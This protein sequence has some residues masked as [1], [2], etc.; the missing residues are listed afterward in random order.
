MLKN[1]MRKIGILLLVSLT[2]FMFV[3]LT[4]A[5][6][7]TV[8]S[9]GCN[10]S[11][12][13]TAINLA[14]PGDTIDVSAGTY[15]E[16]LIISSSQTNLDISG[17]GSSTTTIK[18]IATVITASS[19]LAAPN[20]EILGLGTK[21]HGFT[22]ESP[23]YSSGFYSSGM[24][25]G[26]QNVEIYSNIFK[27]RGAAD[28]G[29]ISQAIQTY[30]KLAVPG[31]DISSL[32]IHNNV[33]THLSSSTAGYEAIWV[34]L[35]EG[36]GSIIIQ[37]NQ[38][39]GDV[40][41]AITTERGKATI[42]NNV[43]TTSLPPNVAGLGGWQGINIGGANDGS[44]STVF[45]LNNTI[46]GAGSGNGFNYGIKL[47]FAVTSS[48]TSVSLINNT[49][50]STGISGIWARYSANGITA[51]YNTLSDNVLGIKNDDVSSLNGENNYWG[52]CTGPGPVGSGSG[53]GVSTNVD[54]SPWLGTCITN[55][56]ISSS[57][58]FSYNDVTL[59]AN[60]SSPVCIGDVT[61]SVKIGSGSWKNYTGTKS[62]SGPANYSVT[63]KSSN[64]S[65][66]EQVN[67]TVF[68][69]DCF[70]HLVKD[71]NENF[72][73]NSKTT[74]TVNPISPNGLNS[75]Y[76]TEPLFTLANP[77]AVNKSYRWDSAIA[78][79]YAIPFNLTD[80]PNQPSQTAGILELNWWSSA[81]CGLEREQNQTFYVDLT[82]PTVDSKTPADGASTYDDTPLISAILDE[83]Y[84]EN[85]GVNKASISMKVD[86]VNRTSQII[87][88]DI[89]TAKVR[90]SYT[91]STP[92]NQSTHTVEITGQDNAG[93]QFS[94]TWQFTV[95]I[96]TSF[97]LNIT[98][99]VNKS[100]TTRQIPFTINLG[101][102]VK[103]L[104]YKDNLN[105]FRTL[106][107]NCNSYN[108][109]ITLGDG[110]H[111]IVIRATDS[112]G[113]SQQQTIE[114][115]IDSTPPRIVSIKPESRK[116]TNGSYVEVKYT[117]TNLNSVTV[118]FGNSSTIIN[119]AL[120][121]C[122]SGTNK[123]CNSSISNEIAQFNGQYIDVYFN[124][125]DGLST[126]L[127]RKSTVF[128][129]TSSPVL[130]VTAPVNNAN[131]KSFIQFNLTVN[132]SSKVEFRDHSTFSPRWTNL[133]TNCNKLSIKKSF[134]KGAH[135]VEVRATDKAGNS[136]TETRTFNMI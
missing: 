49:I 62:S 105:S 100:Y 52:S 70:G 26:A 28:G 86:G 29:E 119:K 12:I 71:G 6:T 103:T 131:Y 111:T 77:N 109:P 16:D 117:E 38:F 25:I 122:P 110:N 14:S 134:S 34:N 39:S 35:D 132:E 88:T 22:I 1:K 124:L 23:S 115:F 125:T 32:N 107:S 37:N 127:S 58:I 99:P 54:Y 65:G 113:N 79:P 89:T 20:I 98:S 8:C 67:W 45:V 11:S 53:S 19:P 135:N 87:K 66:N 126:A 9:S 129:D 69:D 46:N 108:K 84:G 60:V 59:Y 74:L 36:P 18:G 51:N 4:S 30:H 63:I 101:N 15:T 76:V 2:I 27:T 118:L 72:F 68:A 120:T 123:V 130:T 48:F 42:K 56:T 102:I 91:P 136:V 133:C 114:L 92:L 80:I 57:C 73:V 81:S 93:N 128:V 121:N 96:S 61:F 106:C 104:D 24:V 82:T 97:T 5:A 83:H 21:I 3:S 40:F 116:I 85:S 75:W 43:I 50:S 55:K 94:S 33:F 44:I 64:F 10:A 17:A 7:V 31:V 90:V 13:Q 41:R 47:G 112:V 95:N 78:F